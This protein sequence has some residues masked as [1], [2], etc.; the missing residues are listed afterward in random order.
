MPGNAVTHQLSPAF[1]AEF[2]SGA[3][4]PH[5][6][7][8]LQ[9]SVYS[10]RRAMWLA[11]TMTAPGHPGVSDFLAELEQAWTIVEGLEKHAPEVV[12]SILM[13]PST[14]VWLVRALRALLGH[15]DLGELHY[16]RCLAAAAAIRAGHPCTLAVPAIRGVVSLPTVGHVR[17]PT[18]SKMCFVELRNS[19]GSTTLHIGEDAAPISFGYSTA[20]QPGIFSHA[21]SPRHGSWRRSASGD[22]R[23]QSVPRI[24]RSARA[25][26]VDRGRMDSLAGVVRQRMGH[27]HT[28]TPRLR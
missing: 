26:S 9:A 18:E 11:V 17:I 14:G 12:E 24:R 10:Q 20:S 21:I 25:R 4:T 8:E 27:A 7:N 2:C 1:L 23:Q 28:A 19:A 5:S 6:M 3:I 15:L 22:R 16:L 13:H